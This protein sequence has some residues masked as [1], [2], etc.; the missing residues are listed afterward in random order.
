MLRPDTQILWDALKDQKALHG[1]V[2]AG[3]TALSMHLN[4]RLSEDLDFM[5][6][7][8]KLPRA[9]ILALQKSCSHAGFE[10]TPNDSVAD[11]QEWEDCGDDLADYQQNHM[12][13]RVKV[14]FWAPDPDVLSVMGPAD[15]SG[16]RVA[17][18]QEIFDTKC[19]VCADRSK[20]RDWFDLYSLL[21]SPHGFEPVDVFAAFDK[22]GVPSKF[23]I[24]LRRMTK[25]EPGVADEGFESLLENPPSIEE[26]R[27][28]FQEVFHKAQVEVASKARLGRLNCR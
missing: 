23:D 19:L 21:Q 6:I 22:A 27:G 24:A 2:L 5:F 14:S 12:V 16:V 28:F 10:F 26:L 15:E 25:G 11:I 3:G 20:T 7:G 9:R 4:H 1:F 8:A 17:S 18:L 13:G